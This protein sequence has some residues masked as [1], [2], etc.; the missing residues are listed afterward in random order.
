MVAVLAV[1]AIVVY[2]GMNAMSSDGGLDHG[3]IKYTPG[4]PPWMETDPSKKGPGGGPAGPH[5][6]D[7]SGGAP[8][9]SSINK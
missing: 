9:G 5:P 4:K 1:L 7:G 2:L 6:N 3:Q 8:T